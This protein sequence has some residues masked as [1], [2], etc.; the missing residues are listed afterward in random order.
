MP[1]DFGGRG[2]DVLVK[3]GAH[4]AVP[5]ELD[6]APF[7]ATHLGASDGEGAADDGGSS[8]SGGVELLAP[9]LF[10]LLGVVVHSGGLNGGH[11]YSY[12]RSRSGWLCCNDSSVSPA[13]LDTV[14]R[15][16]VYIAIYE[17]REAAGAAVAASAAAKH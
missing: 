16:E 10:S 11:Y 15:S 3:V 5:E 14:L 12:V 7:V 13:T 4:V 1:L 17:K 2:D 6:L 8:G 9:Q